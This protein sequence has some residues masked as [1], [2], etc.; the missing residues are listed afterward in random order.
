MEHGII[1]FKQQNAGS[2]PQDQH[3][4]IEFIQI[5]DIEQDIQFA[6]ALE[7]DFKTVKKL[8]AYSS[9]SYNYQTTYI[10]SYDRYSP[11]NNTDF[12]M[13]TIAFIFF[14]ENSTA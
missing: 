7:K 10:Y 12:W 4:N 8:Y 6:C 1:S 11:S 14:S 2:V 5:I 3:K 13:D 9:Y